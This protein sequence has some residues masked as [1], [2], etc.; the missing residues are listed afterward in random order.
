VNETSIFTGSVLIILVLVLIAI[1]S[2]SAVDAN[3]V[4]TLDRSEISYIYSPNSTNTIVVTG[5]VS[6][7]I[8]AMVSDFY[9]IE[10]QLTATD[11]D[12]WECSVAPS[13][14]MFTE[15]GVKMFNLTFC[16][17]ETVLNRSTNTITVNGYWDTNPHVGQMGESGQATSD[18]V[19]VYVERRGHPRY[20]SST[21]TSP[22]EPTGLTEAS[23][24]YI[25]LIVIA[26]PIF[27]IVLLVIFFLKPKKID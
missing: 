9:S 16:V 2:T 4:I 12:Y 3:V 8:D 25:I 21:S 14:I 11:P 19:S 17:P 26:I 20:P 22:D 18:E 24:F 1:P 23:G 10:V 15:D 6:C 7:E 5:N 27:I 13:N